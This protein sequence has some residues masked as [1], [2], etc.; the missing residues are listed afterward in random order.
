MLPAR[1]AATSAA[2]KDCHLVTRYQPGFRAGLPF[3]EV[4]ATDG[5]AG[6]GFGGAFSTCCITRMVS[7]GRSVLRGL[8]AMG[9]TSQQEH[10]A[11]LYQLIGRC[12]DAWSMVEVHLS[13]LFMA[14][15]DRPTGKSPL[16]FAFD[17]VQSLEVRLS[18]VHASVINDERNNGLFAERWNT[19]YNKITRF[20]RK[21]AQ[22]AHFSLV[23][24]VYDPPMSQFV[25]QPFFT[26]SGISKPKVKPLHRDQLCARREAFTKLADRVLAYTHYIN[27]TRRAR[28]AGSSGP[29]A[30]L[31]RLLD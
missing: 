1:S 23:A 12:L 27:A 14:L 22:L 10:A 20:A 18:M 4:F 29:K 2:R 17:S 15:H 24:E 26:L 7:G 16:R 5:F 21:R 9:A 8:S 25:V 11:E 30:D 6:F 31:A 28:R 3:F 19:L 13:M